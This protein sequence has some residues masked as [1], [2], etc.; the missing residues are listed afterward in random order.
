MTVGAAALAP[1]EVPDLR[2]RLAR[3]LA[4]TRR[5]HRHPHSLATLR[6]EVGAG[7]DWFD[8]EDLTLLSYLRTDRGA[9]PLIR[10]NTLVF[11]SPLHIFAVLHECCH[12][13]LGHRRQDCTG[14]MESRE[15]RDVWLASALVG[16]SAPMIRLVLDGH[17]SS[18][19]IAWLCRVPE[20]LVLIRAGLA[21][22]LG[23]RDG[24]LGEA[25]DLIRYQLGRLEA[26]IE[27]MKRWL[28]RRAQTA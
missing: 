25:L 22:A 10:L 23:E 17:E 1:W 13:I 16:V 19:E 18:S 21:V 11:E 8:E 2:Q 9:K 26:W 24:P 20:P 3:V 7:V 15:E 6:V 28:C 12:H 4:F 14:K 5:Y 27:G